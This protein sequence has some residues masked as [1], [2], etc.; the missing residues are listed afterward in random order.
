MVDSGAYVDGGSIKWAALAGTLV[1]S[2][3]LVAF[4][5]ITR[6]IYEI[7]ALPGTFIDTLADRW[8]ET[9]G[10]GFA[11]PAESLDEA[12]NVVLEQFPIAGPLDWLIGVI[13]LAV[14]FIAVNWMLSRILEG[15]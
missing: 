15:L 6:I 13:V 11:V 5:G 10:L 12:W 9:L 14:F 7:L 2:Y 8:S 3:L 4:D 1:S